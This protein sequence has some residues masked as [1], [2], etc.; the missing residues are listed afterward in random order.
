MLHSPMTLFMNFP[1]SAEH[2]DFTYAE[3]IEYFGA[4]SQRL[5]VAHS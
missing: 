3:H 1:W 2:N 5:D 4:G